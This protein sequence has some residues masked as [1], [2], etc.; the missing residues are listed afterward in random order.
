MDMEEFKILLEKAL[1]Q[2]NKRSY[3]IL[4]VGFGSNQQDKQIY[5]F[6]KQYQ[7]NAQYQFAFSKTYEELFGLKKWVELGDLLTKFDE[8]TQEELQKID[9]I[10]VPFLTRNSLAKLSMGI[11]DNLPL[12]LLNQ[13]MLMGKKII[14]SN[15]C[16]RR[17]TDFAGFKGVDQNIPMQKLYDKHEQTIKSLGICSLSLLEWKKAIDNFFIPNEKTT[18]N[19]KENNSTSKHVLTLSDV[20]KNPNFYLTNEN[21]MTD[22][23]KEFLSEYQ[24]KGDV[25]DGI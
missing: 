17:D 15:H 12:S 25:A 9:L 19:T 3:R 11:A 2:L 24:K 21:R 22:L 23:A 5:S 8:K 20:K 4:V 6:L 16:W 14:V 13:G 1:S 7:A 18:I 10:L